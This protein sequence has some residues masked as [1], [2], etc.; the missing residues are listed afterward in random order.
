MKRLIILSGILL[1]AVFS[2]NVYALTVS[3]ASVQGQPGDGNIS[4]PIS[5]SNFTANN[6]R[7]LELTLKYDAERL[8][9][10]G[11]ESGAL[12]GSW[13][14]Y[15]N[16][17]NTAGVVKICLM[18]VDPMPVQVGTVVIVKFLVKTSAAA[19]Q[20]DLTLTKAIFELSS[21]N[22]INNG[23]FTVDGTGLYMEPIPPSEIKI[24]ELLSFNI[25]ARGE[26]L[27]YS[28]SGVPSGAVF[29]PAAHTFSWVP[30]TGQEGQYSV[31]FSVTAVDGKKVSQTAGYYGKI[32]CFNGSC[33]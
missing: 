32:C 18:N 22:L 12:T 20:S 28:A 17:D 10:V 21:A 2:G 6:I 24:G 9:A 26:N 14:R 30:K 25:N 4:V 27:I 3:V 15:Y 1:L 11:V 29:N 5:I 16:P 8:E 7:N 19:G 33:V 23:K 13:S 31:I